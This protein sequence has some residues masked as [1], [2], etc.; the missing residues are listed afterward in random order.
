M[1]RD[2]SDDCKKVRER[3]WTRTRRKILT[4]GASGKTAQIAARQRVFAQE[5]APGT[6][7]RF[8]EKGSV[9]IAYQEAGFRLSLVTHRFS[10]G[11]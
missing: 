5:A 2:D 3:L 4:T 8:Y 6:G 9:R 7:A 1:P 11:D 10:G